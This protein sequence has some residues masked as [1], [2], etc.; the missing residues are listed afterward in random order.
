MKENESS[1]SLLLIGVDPAISDFILA[2]TPGLNATHLRTSEEFLEFLESPELSHF[3]VLVAGPG[4]GEITV[5]EVAQSL[6]GVLRQAPIFYVHHTRDFG[7]DC[8]SFRKNGF[9]DVFLYPFEK[10]LLRSRLEE[11]V[12]KIRVLP[13]FRSVRVQ[14]I[15][16]DQVLDFDLHVLLPLNG[17]Y[18]RYSAAGQSV[19]ANR[20]AKLKN[21]AVGSFFVPVHQM[22]KFHEYAAGRLHRQTETPGTLS[23]TEKRERL[24]AAI[25][26]LMSEI[27]SANQENGFSDGK[28]LLEDIQKTIHSLVLPVVPGEFRQRLLQ[29]VGDTGG[30]YAHL[31]NVAVFAALFSAVTGVGTPED[32]ALAGMFHDIGLA[33]VPVEDQDNP[34]SAAYQRH[35]EHSVN[36]LKE[37]KL[38][39]SE[40]IQIPL[41][42]HHERA[43]GRGFPSGL[44]EPKLKSESQILGLADEFDELTRVQEGRAPL[45]PE[46]ALVVLRERGDFSRPLVERLIAALHPDTSE[47][48]LEKPPGVIRRI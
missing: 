37:K 16:P 34:L 12:A 26:D 30:N 27:F 3:D 42:Q 24:Q 15:E 19:D 21:T 22:E 14:D 2:V 11:V 9:T 31:A 20:V 7:F 36:L 13:V 48:D 47:G 17:R 43:N 1:L 23:E 28:K 32:L 41:L 44:A 33:V 38:P 5:G 45:S 35:P 40:K 10:D 8:K 6:R 29:V 46:E 39:L 18:V 4:L 25:R